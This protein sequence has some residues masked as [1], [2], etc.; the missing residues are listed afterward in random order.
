MRSESS[1]NGI[2]V[3]TGL[4]AGAIVCFDNTG[5]VLTPVWTP[6]STTTPAPQPTPPGTQ[7]LS[8]QA[9][10]GTPLSNG[11]LGPARCEVCF[12]NG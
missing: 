12:T 5:G 11:N 8:C 2:N 6:C 7:W 1:L 4:K 10:T 9:C 3:A